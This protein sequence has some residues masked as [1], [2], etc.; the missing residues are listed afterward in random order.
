MFVMDNRYVVGAPNSDI[1]HLVSQSA[2]R[3]SGNRCD[4][5]CATGVCFVF[6]SRD[7]RCCL[8]KEFPCFRDSSAINSRLCLSLFPDSFNVSV[9]VGYCPNFYQTNADKSWGAGWVKSSIHVR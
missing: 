5:S 6:D 1:I 8:I 3:A 7:T 2:A 9:I 4:V